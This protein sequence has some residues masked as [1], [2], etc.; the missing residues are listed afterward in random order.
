LRVNNEDNRDLA[1]AWVCQALGRKAEADAALEKL[2]KMAAV[3]VQ[4]AAVYALRGE[5]DKAFAQL[6]RVYAEHDDAL[7]DMRG[8]N[9]ETKFLCGDPRWKAP[10]RRMNLPE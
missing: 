3:S 2:I 9:P 6:D 4:I 8:Y 7:L 1:L 10:L 5:P